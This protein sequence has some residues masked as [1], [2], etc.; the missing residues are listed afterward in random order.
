MPSLLCEYFFFQKF[1]SQNR[2]S[3]PPPRLHNF[4]CIIGLHVYVCIHVYMCIHV[5]SMHIYSMYMYTY[6]SYEYKITSIVFIHILLHMLH[7]VAYVASCCICCILLHTPRRVLLGPPLGG[8][9]WMM[10]K[11]PVEESFQKILMLWKEIQYG[12]Y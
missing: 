10:F 12:Q 11:T 2:V 9:C 4:I 8:I 1:Q 3:V 7:L 5:Q 6:V